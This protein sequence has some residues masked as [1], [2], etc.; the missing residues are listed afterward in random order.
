VNLILYSRVFEEFRHVATTSALL[1]A[2]GLIEREGEVV[3][4]VVQRLEKLS[5]PALG[6]KMESVS[7]SRDFH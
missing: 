5:I 6:K 1:L 3:Y 2:H 7:M 4:I